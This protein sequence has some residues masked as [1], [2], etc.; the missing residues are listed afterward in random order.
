MS[1]HGSAAILK[2]NTT[3]A[4]R[5]DLLGYVTELDVD[6]L[7]STSWP[8][9][10][11]ELSGSGFN[12]VSSAR[13]VDVTHVKKNVFRDPLLMLLLS[14]L[15]CLVGAALNVVATKTGLL[16]TK[17]FSLRFYGFSLAYAFFQLAESEDECFIQCQFQCEAPKSWSF[18]SQFPF[19]TLKVSPFHVSLLYSCIPY[20]TH[21]A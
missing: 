12:F 19:R 14:C 1:K 15:C 10:L 11:A 5:D 6:Y 2:G 17:L 7:L 16:V 4:Y 13:Y 8:Y 9:S 18:L 21:H 20:F 3:A